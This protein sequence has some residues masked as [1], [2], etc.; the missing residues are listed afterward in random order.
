VSLYIAL[1]I[2][3]YL[4]GFIR[5]ER[6]WKRRYDYLIA[7]VFTENLKDALRDIEKEKHQ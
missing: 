2:L 7:D 1:A 4:L 5:G 6:K 3:I